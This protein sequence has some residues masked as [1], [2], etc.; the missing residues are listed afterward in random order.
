[1]EGMGESDGE[2]ADQ[3]HNE[4]VCDSRKK[5]VFSLIVSEG[6]KELDSDCVRDTKNAE[7]RDNIKDAIDITKHDDKVC[8]MDVNDIIFEH[9][10]WKYEFE[11]KI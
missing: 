7:D 9:K 4:D 8:D 11:I 2:E 10:H 5:E 6:V 1:M 3:V